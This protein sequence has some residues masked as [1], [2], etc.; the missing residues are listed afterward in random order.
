V[1]FR[2]PD[3]KS[4]GYLNGHRHGDDSAQPNTYRHGDYS[5]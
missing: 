3:S 5:A 4:D 1:R 2:N